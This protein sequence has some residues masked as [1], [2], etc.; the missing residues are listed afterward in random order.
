MALIGQEKGEHLMK[1]AVTIATICAL[2][3]ALGGCQRASEPATDA[4]SAGAAEAITWPVS[5]N[6]A[7]VGMIDHSADYLFALGNGD[8]PRNENDWHL[9][10]NSAYEI[11]LAGAVI[12]HPGTGPFDA[13][14]VK[15]PEWQRLA[16]ELSGIGEEAVKLAAAKSTDEA[17]W[18]AVGDRLIANCLECHK[19]FKPEIPS[20]GILRGSTERQS[21]G[22]SIFGY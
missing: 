16:Q 6:A 17:A 10:G 21:R 2:S 7:M 12:R 5:I 19:Q 9:V 22:I 1:H 8:M 13:A 3:L 11:V 4:T 18:R 14:W 15:E 20:E